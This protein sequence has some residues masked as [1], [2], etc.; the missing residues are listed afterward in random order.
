MNAEV[1][2]LAEDATREK[3]WKRWG[4][5]LAERQWATVRED[6][7]PDG[8]VWDYFP[9]DHARRRAYRWGEDGLLGIT[10]RECRLCFALALW[11]GKDPMLKERLFG[12]TGPQGN[13]GEDVKECYFYL[14]STPTH[15][16]LKGLYKYPQAEFPY[17]RLVEENQRRGRQEPEFELTDTGIFDGN[18][19]FDVVVEYAKADPEDILVRVTIAN[20]GPEAAR[21]HV[22]PTLWYRNTW[23]WGA[24]HEACK[25]RPS[26]KVA[27]PGLLEAAHPS[28]GRHW[29]A[30]GPGADGRAPQLLFT[31]NETNTRDL[32]GVPNRPPYVKDA[33]NEYVVHRRAEAVNP[34]QVGTKAA[35]LYQV[36]VPAGGEVC[37]RL[38]LTPQVEKAGRAS[39]LLNGHRGTVVASKGLGAKGLLSPALSSR[40][41]EGD[42]AKAFDKSSDSRA[43]GR[44]TLGPGST[45][46]DS[47]EAVETPALFSRKEFDQV[48]QDRIR[49]ADEF[50]AA[51]LPGGLSEDEARVVRQAYAGLLW[52][53]QF[54]HYIVRD[55]LEGDAEQPPP[56]ASRASGRNADW[57]HLYNR[58]IISMPDKW[59][60]PWYAA[61]D[62]AFHMIPFARIDPDFAKQQLVLFLREWY[63]HPNGQ[64]PAYEF[65]FGDVN[66][67]V[68]AWSCWRVFKMTAGRGQRDRVFLS[69]CFQKLV[70]S[71]TWWVN[72][73]DL[74]GRNL[75]AGGFLGLDNIGVFDRSKPLPTGGHLQQADGTAWMAFFCATMLS[76][77]LELARDNPA[78]QDMASKFFEH[79]VAIADA[80]NTQGGTGL[81]DEADG[82]YYDQL[83]VDGRTIPLKVRSLVGLI[84]LLA[85]E[86]LDDELIQ[87]MR[88]FK[89]RMD[90]F[91][92]HRPDLSQLISYCC[93]L[94]KGKGHC[95]R[96]LAIPT[97]EQLVRVL[98]YMLDENEFLSSY[99][100][101]SLSRIHRDRPYI[102]RLDGQE[103]R[104]DYEPG[105]STTRF[106]GGNSNWRGPVWLPA[107]Y[108]L[109]EALERYHHFYG[110]SLRVECPTGSGKMLDLLQ[111]ANDLRRR[112]A[113]L[114]LPDAQG[115]RPCHGEDR[116]FAEDLNWRDLV[117]FHEYFH[118]ETGRG[119]GAS[120]QTGW[121]ALVTRLIEEPGQLN[122]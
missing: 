20:R 36:E 83:R 12:L 96:L 69:R 75:F 76:I 118:G 85:V 35:A 14:D 74:E 46:E 44:T 106:F 81:W 41:G 18:R 120:H 52:S 65:N 117:L 24:K 15:S 3:N 25:T 13:H 113:R 67:P 43:G 37:V 61:W 77:A 121:T 112:L 6:Y 11:N 28:L 90:W 105:E 21:L 19:Y 59:E 102:F 70:I 47:G 107:N 42:A 22:L 104:V 89:K 33:F 17:A 111:V 115:R 109:I 122:H 64:L 78:T 60:Y 2:R 72:R 54:Y 108:L 68:H 73:K 94:E 116:R 58:D 119:L 49:E 101:R 45:G 50:Y 32:F 110:D 23:S 87:G 34:V 53:K 26:I 79:F 10:D 5:Y 16:Y 1:R 27:G 8:K 51:R 82:F 55:W 62:L 86:V 48:F 31:E 80:M 4:P 7:S 93:L 88:G 99:G 91:L 103:H 29:L 97:R 63:M 9:H 40:G 100:I 57:V 39:R 71:F 30:A 92:E 95:H 84:P 66:P 114:F 98:R 38:R 56:P